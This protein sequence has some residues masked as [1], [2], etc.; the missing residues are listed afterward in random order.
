MLRLLCFLLPAIA[1]AQTD[2]FPLQIGNQWFYRSSGFG[3]SSVVSIEVTGRRTVG[4]QPYFVLKDFQSRELLVRET[5]DGVLMI[6]DASGEGVW[7]PFAAP[8]GGSFS[9]AVDACSTQG[10]VV[11]HAAHYE[12]PV[13][14]FDDALEVRYSGGCADA[15]FTRELFLPWVGLVRREETTIGGP[16][17]YDLIYA[18]LGG[19]TFVSESQVSFILT[20]DKS[21]YVENLQPPVDP[22][23]A[24]AQMTARL[25][26]RNT[27]Q[28][29][30][31][32]TF[33]TGQ[34]FDLVLRNERGDEVYRWS[35]GRVFTQV[36]RN[37]AV[38]G[39]KN[40]VIVVPLADA[41][42]NP[43]PVGQYTAEAS[44]ATTPPGQYT[45]RLSFQITAVH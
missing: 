13:G 36:F 22:R 1:L 43:L 5:S 26:L 28:P 9:S 17:V 12:G 33:P 21:T 39:E 10:R 30:L 27:Q 18:E 6:S 31:Q 45:A 23:R 25:T 38:S 29:P 20:L 32:L 14:I 42:G 37:V 34:D 40:W 44:L 8:D 16:R 24:V 2:Y 3:G 15:G 7:V 35:R 4:A 11:S 41:G 19:V